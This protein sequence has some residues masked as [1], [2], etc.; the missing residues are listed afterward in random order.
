VIVRGAVGD[1]FDNEVGAARVVVVVVIVAGQ[2]GVDRGPGR[3][4]ECL[5][6]QV[7][8][9]GIVEALSNGPGPA[10]VPDSAAHAGRPREE[11]VLVL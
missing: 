4:L 6:R 7:S 9:A 8:V 11:V 10:D 5:L 2:D 1:E 3:R